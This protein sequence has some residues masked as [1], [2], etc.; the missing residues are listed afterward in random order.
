MITCAAPRPNAFPLSDTRSRDQ[1]AM[2][3]HP[4]PTTHLPPRRTHEPIGRWQT[5]AEQLS[6]EASRSWKEL[7]DEVMHGKRRFGVPCSR[8]AQARRGK[9]SPS[10]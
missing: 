6:F 5:Q 2:R 9:T 4:G 3:M 10:S 1:A 8:E 7:E